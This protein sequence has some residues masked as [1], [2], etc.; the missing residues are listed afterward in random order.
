MATINDLQALDPRWLSGPMGA[1]WRR[2]SLDQKAVTLDRMKC[3]VKMRFPELAPADAQARIGVERQIDRSPVDTNATYGA[4]LV[5][6][7]NIWRWSGT[8]YGVLLALRDAGYPHAM[9]AIVHGRLYSLASD[10]DLV[11]ATLPAGS[12]R[13]DATS[14]FWSKFVVV[15]PSNPWGEN[16][17]SDDPRIDQIRRLVRRWK[18]RFST[19]SQLIVINSGRTLGYPIRKLGTGDGR[20]L[21]GC[22]IL[23]YS[24]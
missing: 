2:A 23:H 12:W 20:K 17:A 24:P 21:G 11:I 19:F 5:D 15:L 22:S 13:C 9:I 14:V 1:A 7:W 6:A 10:G 16:P 3:A 4:R 18:S 8:A